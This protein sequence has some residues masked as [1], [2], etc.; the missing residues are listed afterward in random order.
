MRR[1]PIVLGAF[2]LGILAGLGLRPTPL[3]APSILP[4]PPRPAPGPTPP[5]PVD[6][7]SLQAELRDRDALIQVL[8]REIAEQDERRKA[9]EARIPGGAAPSPARKVL[10]T[11]IAGTWEST[12]GP[13]TLEHPPVRDGSPVPVTG[14]WIQGDRRGLIPSGSFDPATGIVRFAWRQDWD[15]QEGETLLLVTQQGQQLFGCY[16]SNHGGGQWVLTRGG[17]EEQ[18][19]GRGNGEAEDGRP[20]PYASLPSPARP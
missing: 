19:P 11:S 6:P 12:C 7:G 18:R 17:L 14:F 13:V 20:A 15:E 3:P 4:P 9:I 1:I 5:R 2:L 10:W 8:R 16:T